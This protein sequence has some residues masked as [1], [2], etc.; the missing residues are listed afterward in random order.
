MRQIR[1]QKGLFAFLISAFC[2]LLCLAPARAATP[3]LTVG[4]ASGQAGTTVMNIPIT[5]D[6]GTSSVAGI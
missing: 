5:F 2:T 4:S 1:E 6:P 3:S